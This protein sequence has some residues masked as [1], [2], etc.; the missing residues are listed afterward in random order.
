[1]E[2]PIP[3]ASGSPSP[4]PPVRR[5]GVFRKTIRGTRWLL[6][7]GSDWAGVKSI[8][9]GA[10]L[11]GDL[12]HASRSDT[13]ARERV[14]VDE[15]RTLDIRATA[16]SQGMTEDALLRRLEERRR[17]TAAHRLWDLH[18]GLPVP[19][20]LVVCSGAHTHG[21]VAHHAGRGLPAVL[22]AVF[23]DRLLQC[24]GQLPDPL[25]PPCELARV[26]NGRERVPAAVKIRIP[27]RRVLLVF[28]VALLA[29]ACTVR[30]MNGS[31]VVQDPQIAFS[32]SQSLANSSAFLR[33]PTS[34]STR[35]PDLAPESSAIR[36]T[37]WRSPAC[38]RADRS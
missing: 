33:C 20:R 32:A 14:F 36:G 28:P 30:M 26:S 35:G 11:I 17:Q 37:W 24:V 15:D 5:R 2:G 27:L 34:R 8:R 4:D 22:R 29:S 3:L 31:S 16:F 6:G 23:F 9:R 10:A 12:A 13:S 21:A 25:W 18:P 1:M 7:G 38:N 19:D